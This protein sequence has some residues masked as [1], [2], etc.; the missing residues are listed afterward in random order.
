[1][2]AGL[3]SWHPSA[4]RLSDWVLIQQRRTARHLKGDNNED[5]FLKG[6][7]LLGV[8]T[9]IS[10]GSIHRFCSGPVDTAVAVGHT[11]RNLQA[12]YVALERWLLFN[13]IWM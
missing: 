11:M 13:M 3:P 10:V 1:M 4:T 2:S 6:L 12:S 9:G 8:A 5:H 7:W